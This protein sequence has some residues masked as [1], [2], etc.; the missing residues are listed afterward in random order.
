MAGKIP[1][2]FIDELLNRVD[3]VDLVGER[4]QLKR[5]GGNYQALCPF[6]N[7]KTPSFTVSQPKQFYHCF[8]CGAHGTAIRFLMEYDRMDFRDAVGQ[9]ARRI[10][11]E[12]PEGARAVNVEQHERL[13]QMLGRAAELYQKWLYDHPSRQCAMRYLKSR[14]LNA[15]IATRFGL[16]FAPPGWDHLARSIPEREDLVAVGL[17]IQ[18]AGNQ[19]Y[20]R[21]RDRIMFPI[22]DRRGRTIGFGGRA[23][24]DGNPKYL[25]SPDSPIFH[26]GQELYG[27]DKVLEL[28]RR[29]AAIVVVEGYMDVVALAQYGLPRV[30]ATLGT[31]TS[32]L[33]VERLFRS[34]RDLIFC[35]DGDAAGRQAAWRALLSTL[36]TLREGRQAR[37]LFL[38]EGEDPDSF[39]RSKGQEATAAALRDARPLS[40]FLLEHLALDVDMSTIDG[41]ARLV[42]EALPLLRRLPA[43]VFRRMLIERLALLVQLEPGYIEACTDA[44][45]KPGPKVG[46]APR[47]GKMPMVRRT[48]V[49]LALALLLHRPS[50]AQLVN[51]VE[52]LRDSAIPGLPLLVQLLELAHLKPHINSPGLLE[53]YRDSEHEAALWK[54]ATWD[55]MVPELG[56]EAEFRGALARVHALLHTKRLQYLNERLQRGELTSAEWREWVSLKQGS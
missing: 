39:V 22:R 54:L 24:G 35:F 37:F 25:N 27:L 6:H 9:L 56:M 21:F 15:E 31:A 4:V 3:I 13:Y 48:P 44:R 47:G 8:G 55:H 19:P 2:R 18:K 40:D 23:L 53:H 12:V 45:E 11:L 20:D 30:V 49:R 51:D 17:L 28:D 41:R 36:P 33:Q 42:D 50:L 29:P 52:S 38:P 7:E 16:G 34:T 1:E 26:K 10:G 5:L 46:A 43:D 32:T 14:G